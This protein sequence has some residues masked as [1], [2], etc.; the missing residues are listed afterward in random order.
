RKVVEQLKEALKK[1]SAVYLATDPDREG[2]AISWHLT[3]AAALKKVPIHRVV[4]HEITEDAI[5]EAFLHPRSLD[6]NLVD[7]QQA[8]RILDRLVGYKISPLLCRN[9]KSKLSA[10]RVQ[11]AALKLIVDR[12]QEIL[13]FVPQEYWTV[14]AELAKQEK[15]GNDSFIAKFIGRSA[16]SHPLEIH[17]EQEAKDITNQLNAAIYAVSDVRKKKV[18]RQPAPPFITSTLQQEAWR[19]LH[20]SAPRTMALAQ[21][22]Y[23]GLPIAEEGAM[24][25]ITYMRTDSTIVSETALHE[26]R[27]FITSKFGTEFLP[28]QVRRFTKKVKGAQEAHEA[29]RPTRTSREPDSIKQY[30]THDQGLLYELIWKRMV[31]SQMA[32]ASFQTTTVDIEAKEKERYLLRATGSVMEFPGFLSLYSETKDESDTRDEEQIRLPRLIQG[33]QLSL[34]DLFP[35]QHFT[36]PPPRY[37]E[38]SLIKSME[39]RGIGRPSTYAPIISTLYQREYVHREGGKICPLELGFTVSQL[40][41]EHFSDIVDTGFT[42]QME[43]K[44]DNIAQGKL[45]WVAVLRAFYDPFE[46][47]LHKA[48]ENMVSLKEPPQP[49]DETCPKCGKPMVVRTG[50]YGKFIACTGFPKCKTTKALADDENGDKPAPPPSQTTDETCPE[51]GKSMAIKKGRFGEFLA[52]SGYPDCKTTKRLPGQKKATYRKKGSASKTKKS[53]V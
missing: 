17:T 52:C 14:E 7:A 40:L 26:T 20:F 51:C 3:E 9:V 18:T 39:E 36:Q 33:E 6:M 44:L 49:T 41:T 4:F 15:Q 35:S 11:S 50:R 34:I 5:K 31:A 47:T 53:R 45:S 27:E 30:L 28:S 16:D 19:K 10:G 23:E 48:S 1:T 32:A 22:L 29:I 42:A 21:Q 38:A 2:E 13:A 12:E 37:N 8:R 25:L 46:E 43:E 24:G